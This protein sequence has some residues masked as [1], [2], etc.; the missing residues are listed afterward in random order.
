M[1]L[2]EMDLHNHSRQ[3]RWAMEVLYR[4]IVNF[5][6]D[7]RLVEASHREL[8]QFAV[9]LHNLLRRRQGAA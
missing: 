2:E 1:T 4:G 7:Q 5:E 8:E 3:A 9:R 6:D